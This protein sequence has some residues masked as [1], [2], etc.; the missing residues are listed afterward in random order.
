WLHTVAG[1]VRAPYKSATTPP[2]GRGLI[3]ADGDLAEEAVHDEKKLR[4]PKLTKSIPSQGDSGALAEAAKL[5]VAAE[6]P[7]ILADRMAR[8]QEGIKRLVEL[9]EALN[10]P[11]VDIGGG[12][13]FSPP[14]ILSRGASKTAHL[15]GAR[16]G[17]V[18]G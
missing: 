8:S 4:I 6:R 10:A 5:L 7:V 13:N 17:V 11:V 15:G 9:A 2:R 3:T 16:M 18:C 12:M 1:R 14:P